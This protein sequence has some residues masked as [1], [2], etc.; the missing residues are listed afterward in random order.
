[1]IRHAA[2]PATIRIRTNSTR[3]RIDNEYNM[4]IGSSSDQPRKS[5][6]N[7]FLLGI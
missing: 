1:M 4:Q 5:V 6:A 3:L 2:T 7:T